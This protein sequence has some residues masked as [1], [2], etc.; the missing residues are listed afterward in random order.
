M[1]QKIP[2]LFCPC[3]SKLLY[4]DCCYKYH[5]NLAPIP[6]ALTLM[7]ARF[8]A[9]ALNKPDFIMETTH[10]ENP[11]FIA[12]KGTWRRE[13]SQFSES[14]VFSGL[15]ILEFVPGEEQA[16][17]TFC[18]HLKQNRQNATFTEKSS[19]VKEQGKWLYKSGEVQ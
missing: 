18:A 10:P 11:G 6:D 19:F 2:K 7:R 3:Q 9:Y 15:D 13:I 12:N 5:M 8:A 14:T 4:A 16:T 17:V 1:T